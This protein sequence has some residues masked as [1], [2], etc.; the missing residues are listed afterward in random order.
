MAYWKKTM[1]KRKDGS[2]SQK[3]MYDNIRAKA[4]SNKKTW[5]KPKKPTAS[6]LK[7]DKKIKRTYKK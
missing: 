4:K 3:W 7:Q 5:A 6:M 1:V 2:Y